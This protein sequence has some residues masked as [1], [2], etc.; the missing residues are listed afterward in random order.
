M[1]SGTNYKGK[2]K[3]TWFT[4]L[5][6]QSSQPYS[7]K[8]SSKAMRNT[9]SAQISATAGNTLNSV[10]I[11]VDYMINRK[12]LVFLEDSTEKNRFKFKNAI[13]YINNKRLLKINT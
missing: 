6:L 10:V 3:N 9:S 12:S 13:H 2:K 8:L 5:Q 11:I 1:F 7:G 4:E